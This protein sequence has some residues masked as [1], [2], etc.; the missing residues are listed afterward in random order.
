MKL[1]LQSFT[2]RWYLV[3]CF[4]QSWHK[5]EAS[6]R[7]AC[8]STCARCRLT[9]IPVRS[10]SFTSPRLC[11]ACTATPCLTSAWDCVD[12]CLWS[13]GPY[14][15]PTSNWRFCWTTVRRRCM[16][17]RK[18]ATSSLSGRR[19]VCDTMQCDMIRRRES[20]TQ[21]D[22]ADNTGRQLR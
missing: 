12:C 13:T 4:L 14:D 1:R 9:C 16:P 5:V 17:T 18:T 22:T 6:T 19:Y 3:E 15:R 20:L 10:S 7:A 8:T 21:T 2:I 11:W